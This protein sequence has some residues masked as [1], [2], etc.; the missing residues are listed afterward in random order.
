MQSNQFQLFKVDL[1]PENDD[2]Y[3]M[4]IFGSTWVKKE[5]LKLLKVTSK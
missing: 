5:S 2:T 4:H 3:Y 1:K